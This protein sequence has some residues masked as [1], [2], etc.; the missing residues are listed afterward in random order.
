[1][2]ERG[3]S[4][5]QYRNRMFSKSSELYR[6]LLEESLSY[7]YFCVFTFFAPRG[8]PGLRT[9]YQGCRCLRQFAEIS[10]NNYCSADAGKHDE[11]GHY[12]QE[13]AFYRCLLIRSQSY[14]SSLAQ[15]T[16]SG[17]FRTLSRN[18]LTRCLHYYF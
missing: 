14:K 5:S 3:S 9:P 13:R 11:V 16:M 6:L 1:M 12:T 15:T 4:S 18:F 2:R 17:V 7:N 10:I 8:Y